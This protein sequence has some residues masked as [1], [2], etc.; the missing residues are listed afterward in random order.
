VASSSQLPPPERDDWLALTD[1]PLPLGLLASWP[2]R[3]G[4][5]AVVMFAGTVRD[6]AEGRPGVTCL[7]YEAYT[8][9][10]LRAMQEIASEVRTTWPQV[11]RLAIVHRTGQLVPTEVSVVVA[12]SAPHR[13]EAFDAARFA[14]ESVKSRVPIWKRESWDGGSDWGLGAQALVGPPVP[15]RGGMMPAGSQGR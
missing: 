1:Q 7:E 10:A 2:V 11:G 8:S 9:A 15:D 4:C 14:I 6:H 13:G 12:V 5:G 3:P